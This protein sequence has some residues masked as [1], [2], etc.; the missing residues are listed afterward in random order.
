MGENIKKS[1]FLSWALRHDPGRIGLSLDRGGWAEIHELI[2]C[3]EGHGVNL[4]REIILEITEADRKGRYQLS[5]DRRR[6]RAVYGHSQ[7]VELDFEQKK[8]PRVLYHGTAARNVDSIMKNGIKP[9]RR[10]YVHLS[11]GP[12][13]AIDVGRRHGRVILLEVD[14]GDMYR[15]GM[16]F[17]QPACEIWLTSEVPSPYIRI[18]YYSGSSE[19]D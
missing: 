7:R 18:G 3:A 8:P 13:S 15:D 12:E 4:N 6:I 17:F 16:K 5:E 1:K 19:G 9:L 10:Q 2:A 14:S 11:S